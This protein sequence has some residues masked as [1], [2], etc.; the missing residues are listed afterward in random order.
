[1]AHGTE[2]PSK[3]RTEKK[4]LSVQLLRKGAA[5]LLDLLL[6]FPD[7]QHLHGREPVGVYV[8]RSELAVS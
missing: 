4:D 5:F 6:R 2:A 1:L 3:K 7:L 8:Q